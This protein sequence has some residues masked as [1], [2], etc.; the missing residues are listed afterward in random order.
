MNT[1]YQ[2]AY[3]NA[4]RALNPCHALSAEERQARGE[5]LKEMAH[6]VA[7]RR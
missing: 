2:F 4:A 5:Q 6:A 7:L 3:R 1:G